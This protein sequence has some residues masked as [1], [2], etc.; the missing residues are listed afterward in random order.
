[1]RGVVDQS[2]PAAPAASP[3]LEA[4]K[5]DRPEEATGERGWQ[6]REENSDSP[7]GRAQQCGDWVC[8]ARRGR[9]PKLACCSCNVRCTASCTRAGLHNLWSPWIAMAMACR[10]RACSPSALLPPNNSEPSPAFW[11]LISI[12]IDGS[13]A[14]PNLAL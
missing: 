14:L 5:D 3:G 4:P 12:F 13:K 2:A 8:L 6:R 9:P 11:N 1:M 10:R 7:G